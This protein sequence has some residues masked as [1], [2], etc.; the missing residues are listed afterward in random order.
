MPRRVRI[1]FGG[2]ADQVMARGNARQEIVRDD[3]D[4]RRL[5]DGLEHTVVPAGASCC[6]TS[7]WEMTHIWLARSRPGF[8]A[9]TPRRRFGNWPNGWAFRLP[10]ACPTCRVGSTRG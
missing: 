5:I 8:A 9:A 10:A 4:R 6:A 3:A 7:S 1:E 2:A